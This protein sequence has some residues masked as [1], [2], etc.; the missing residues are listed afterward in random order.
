MG[1]VYQARDTRLDRHVAIKVLGQRHLEDP[2]A[3]ARFEQEARVI[4]A[5]SHPNICALHD[6]SHERGID[7][8]V[9]EYLEGE[10]LADRLGRQRLHSPMSKAAPL[11]AARPAPR[12]DPAA[13]SR[14]PLPLD[15]VVRV[16]TQ[17]ADA[18]A[19]AHRAGVVHRDLKPANVMLT[20]TGVKVL[21]FGLAKTRPAAGVPADQSPTETSPLTEAG[22]IAGT[23][24]YMAPEQLQGREVDARTDIFAFGEIVYEMTSGRRPFA[25]ESPAGLI[26]AILDRDPEP[27]GT[28]QPSTPQVLERLVRKCL[29]KDPDERWQSAS[30]VADELRWISSGSGLTRDIDARS[31]PDRS[32]A[33]RLAG[34]ASAS[35]AL[36]AI[37]VGTWRWM[38]GTAPVGHQTLHRQ[39]TF[40]GDVVAAALSPDGQTVAYGGGLQQ[41]SVG[42]FVRD[43]TG[44]QALQ[45]W[46]GEIL[47]DV[48]WTPDGSQI[49]V[50]GRQQGQRGLWVVPRLGGV[51]RHI[52]VHGPLVDV[53]PDGT[54]LSL[55]S[56]GER[57]FRIVSLKD[58]GSRPVT[59]G[60]VRWLMQLDWSSR[61]GRLVLLTMD[62]DREWVVL[63]TTPDGGQQRAVYSGK[64]VVRAVCSSP[65]A[66]VV[67]LVREQ[68]GTSE[69]LTVP[70]DGGPHRI[71]LS[72]LPMAGEPEGIEKCTVSADGQQLLYSR[73]SRHARLWRYDLT[74]SASRTTVLT[75]ASSQYVFPAVSPD[76]E[77]I[78]ATEGSESNSQIVK[79]P[80]GGGEPIN[81]G[82]GAG[83]AWSPD[84]QQ[85]AFVSD[86]SGSRRV[87]IVP[88]ESAF[89]VEVSDSAVSNSILTWLPDGRLAWPSTDARN[90][91]IRNLT[92]GENEFLVRDPSVGWVTVPRFAPDGALV[93]VRWNRQPEGLW[94][95]TWPGREERFLAAGR[96]EAVP[97]GWSGDGEWVY[98]SQ[99]FGRTLFRISARTGKSEPLGSFPVGDFQTSPCDLTPDRASIVCSLTETTADAWVMEHFDQEIP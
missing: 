74:S 85:L 91:R 8:L 16:A 51:A 99:T 35:L 21:D 44:G 3:R 70:M 98:A 57:G 71:L 89:A 79:I 66:D 59:L 33:L 38:G 77:W 53:S 37:A 14:S 65:I 42:L 5:L 12:P 25:G 60:G 39:I 75:R 11:G 78:A 97:I 34:I 54:A 83:P 50:S 69:V 4:A 93:A 63:T 72:G 76:G 52:A 67:Y 46:A 58:G 61:S 29:A 82:P 84:G 43:V 15:E 64:E 80:I 18:L 19:A 24:P 30:D 86:R 10:T 55:A 56:Q 1:E 31:R 95:L 90:Y 9:M 40:A 68:S 27:L 13:P 6:V 45:I 92:T 88:A 49:V 26:A 87:W 7:F 47:T 32:R 36:V 17:L 20:K 28:L 94:L 22:I 48:A 96:P 81:L 41:A 73:A 2:L 62:D 23:L